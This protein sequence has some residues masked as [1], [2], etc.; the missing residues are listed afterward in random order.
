MESLI[1]SPP[2]KISVIMN[3]LSLVNMFRSVSIEYPKR[4]FFAW[5]GLLVSFP[6]FCVYYTAS[7]FTDCGVSYIR[8]ESLQGMFL[9]SS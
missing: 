9:I 6:N 7:I 4:D 2:K 8:H 3:V 1:I 5:Q